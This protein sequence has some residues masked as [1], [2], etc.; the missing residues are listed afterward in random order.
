MVEHPDFI[1]FRGGDKLPM[2]RSGVFALWNIAEELRRIA[3]QMER[4]NG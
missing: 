1:D 3:D 4:N 2:L